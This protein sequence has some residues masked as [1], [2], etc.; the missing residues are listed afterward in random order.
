M[1]DWKQ[2]DRFKNME[3]FSKKIWLASPTM[4]GE[5]LLYMTEA[6]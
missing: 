1:Y 4:N 2:D 3:P 6:Y 5:E